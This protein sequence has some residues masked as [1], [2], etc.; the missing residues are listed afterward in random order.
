MAKRRLWR[1][2]V[3]GVAGLLAVYVGGATLAVHQMIEGLLDVPSP[4]P[5]ETAAPMLPTDPNVIGYRGDP[6]VALG[7]AFEE[8]ALPVRRGSAPAWL[9]PADGDSKGKTW[10]IYVHGIGGSR[11]NGYRYVE[12]LHA[13]GFPVLLISYLNDEGAP[14]AEEGMYGY[15]VIEWPDLVA[16]VDF[17]RKEGAADALLIGDSMG[18][19]IIGQ[20]FA[21]SDR[22][23]GVSAVILDSPALDF[24]ARVNN[25]LAPLNLPLAPVLTALAE[26][27]VEIQHG[28]P[29]AE[30]V[31]IDPLAAFPGPMLVIH[32]TGDGIIPVSTS[33]QL[34]GKRAGV[35]SMLRMASDHLATW[36]DHPAL[37]ESTLQVFLAN[38]K[39]E[40][41]R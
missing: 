2:L 11:E 16:A 37:F 23:W 25:S 29:I 6:Q 30:A 12:T 15:G 27:T 8:V 32:G 17:V 5:V 10:A 14:A 20:F 26:R 3:G 34:V 18:G 33:D 31:G 28:V 24:G 40:A 22:G 39:T 35:T 4:T 36:T 13:A 1:W 9:I 7:L 38:L 41:P 21:R 19:G